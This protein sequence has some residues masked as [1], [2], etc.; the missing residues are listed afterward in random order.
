[1]SQDL[2]KTPVQRG[3]KETDIEGAEEYHKNNSTAKVLRIYVVYVRTRT[4][5]ISATDLYLML[6]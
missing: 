5:Q 3:E 4:N 2:H 6:L 1:M